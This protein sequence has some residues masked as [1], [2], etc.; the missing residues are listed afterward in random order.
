MNKAEDT[1]GEQSLPPEVVVEINKTVESIAP[2]LETIYTRFSE[3]GYGI[4]R[5][6]L[7]NC[8]VVLTSKRSRISSQ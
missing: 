6:E 8:Q 1:I 7:D 4:M 5:F 3:F 2:G